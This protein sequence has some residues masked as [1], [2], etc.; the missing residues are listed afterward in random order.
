MQWHIR[1]YEYFPIGLWI[2]WLLVT[3]ASP[4]RVSMLRP[5]TVRLLLIS[6][7]SVNARFWVKPILGS[8]V[9][10][11]SSFGLSVINSAKLTILSTELVKLLLPSTSVTVLA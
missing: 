6:C 9:L 7:N 4:N 5:I 2:K 3:S 10:L 11:L 1:L 8:E